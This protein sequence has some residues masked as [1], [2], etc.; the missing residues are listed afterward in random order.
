MGQTSTTAGRAA[1]PF[2]APYV[3]AFVAVLV[4]L[5][6][7]LWVP[8]MPPLSDY[9][10]HVARADVLARYGQE[11]AYRAFYAPAWGPYPNLAFDLFTVPVARVVGAETAGKLFLSLTVALFATGSVLFGRALLG[12]PSLRALLAAFFAYSESFLLGYASFSFGM[13]LM[14]AA[15]SLFVGAGGA[16]TSVKRQ[17]GFAALALGVVVSHAAAFVTLCLACGAI[18]L[19][20][21]WQAR[22]RGGSLAIGALVRALAPL[23]PAG[24]YFLSWLL[25]F[26][27]HS[28]D[29]GFSSPGTSARLLLQ[30]MLPT[31]SARLDLVV[32]GACALAAAAALALAR[33]LAVD[34]RLAAAACLLAAAVFGAPADFGGGYEANGRYVVGAWLFGLFA[35]SPREPRA[36]WSWARSAAAIAAITVLFARQG[37][38]AKAFADLDRD[39]AGQVALLQ[40]LP[41]GVTLGNLTFLDGRA[42]RAVQ[43]RERAVLHATSVAVLTRHANVPTLYAI[44]GVQPLA[45]RTP[46]YDRHRFRAT[47]K[48]PFELERIHDE[49]DAA[50]VCHAPRELTDALV[51]KGATISGEHASCVLY[52]WR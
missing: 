23:L 48:G 36:A 38:V 50:L 15:L 12:R 2:G 8:A 20:S 39:L 3:A 43:L 19:V 25:F 18:V 46:R 45:H 7:P 44:K 11:A 42:P 17:V 21:A 28:A 34:A 52:V 37:L 35:I 26:A 51:A 1:A 22:S 47:D 41:D 16:V 29:R 6:A 14:L 32:L 9:L 5:I 27:D 4:A 40:S 31:Y 33:P 49:L 30:T 10:N 24:L 13:G